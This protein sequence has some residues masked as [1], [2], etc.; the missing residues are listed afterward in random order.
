MDKSSKDRIIL[1]AAKY[2]Y[3]NQEQKGILGGSL[4]FEVIEE[5]LDNMMTN[6][7]YYDDE[8]GAFI[9]K[10]HLRRL[11]LLDG[12]EIRDKKLVRRID[13]INSYIEKES[14]LVQL[15]N[16]YNLKTAKGHYDLAISAFT[17][18]EWASCNAQIRSYVESFY[19]FE[20]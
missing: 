15:L 19:G 9:E 14:L 8:S 20:R 12:F 4:S 5:V 13:S 10:P 11:L 3:E 18:G 16:K 1:S 6:E 2:I 7:Y 17:R